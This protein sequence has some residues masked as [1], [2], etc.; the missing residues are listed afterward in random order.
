MGF[1]EYLSNIDMDIFI[2]QNSIGLA[3]VS[4]YTH[5]GKYLAN[6]TEYHYLIRLKIMCV[7]TYKVKGFDDL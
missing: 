6:S 4:M 3:C 5:S 7:I 1:L 2:G